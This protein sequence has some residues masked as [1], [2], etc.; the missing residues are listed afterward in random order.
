MLQLYA[1]L[2]DALRKVKSFIN[3]IIIDKEKNGYYLT[4]DRF[5][6]ILSLANQLHK[7]K[8]TYLKRPKRGKIY[9]SENQILD[10]IKLGLI[11]L[12]QAIRPYKEAI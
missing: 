9:F 12:S 2:I 8:S 11:H 5:F 10:L 3:C 4:K 7:S 6:D 1:L